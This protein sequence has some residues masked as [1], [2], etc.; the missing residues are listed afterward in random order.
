MGLT[1][2]WGGTIILNKKMEV[3]MSTVGVILQ[4]IFVNLRWTKKNGFHHLRHTVATALAKGQA[5]I[6]T[7]FNRLN[8]NAAS[9]FKKKSIFKHVAEL[10]WRPTGVA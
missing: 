6:I 7:E 5:R 1:Y 3:P 4:E 10:I 9:C 2:T 8:D